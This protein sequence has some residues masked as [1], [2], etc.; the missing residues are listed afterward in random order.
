VKPGDKKTVSVDVV[1]TDDKPRTVK[2]SKEFTSESGQGVYMY[3]ELCLKLSQSYVTF[4]IL[5][6]EVPIE[7]IQLDLSCLLFPAN[8][9]VKVS[10]SNNNTFISCTGCMISLKLLLFKG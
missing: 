10:E 9:N 6:N 1:P 5:N 4:K 2:H 3:E 7:K 8:Q